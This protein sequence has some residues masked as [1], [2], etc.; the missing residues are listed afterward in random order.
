MSDQVPKIVDTPWIGTVKGI[1]IL[2]EVVDMFY[3]EETD[4]DE[5]QFLIRV[6]RGEVPQNLTI[7]DKVILVAS[8]QDAV[9]KR[10]T[11]HC[12]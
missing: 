11:V 9:R 8:I 3:H 5:V 4:R 7:G 10:K 2:G 12:E 6:P 1:L